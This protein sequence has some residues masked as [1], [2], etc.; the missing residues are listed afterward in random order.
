MY[1]HFYENLGHYPSIL[2]CLHVQQQLL[3]HLQLC[4]NTV[5][6]G[7]PFVIMQVLVVQGISNI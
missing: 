1:M 5:L 2:D 7:S 6:G 3:Q 4:W